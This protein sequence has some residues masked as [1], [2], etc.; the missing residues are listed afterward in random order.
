[1]NVE[2][3]DLQQIVEQFEAVDHTVEFTHNGSQW[4]CHAT[5]V[6]EM[7]FEDPV[8]TKHGAT[9]M[10]AARVAMDKVRANKP[11]LWADRQ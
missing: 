6:G 4:V 11:E 7:P 10:A 9:K 3:M 1:M 8:T 2:Q 5:Y